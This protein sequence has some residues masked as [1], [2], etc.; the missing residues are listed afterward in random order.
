MPKRKPEWQTPPR[1]PAG[2]NANLDT[3]IRA[4]KQGDLVVLSCR[5]GATGKPV[6]VVC[7]I[8]RGVEN[9][10]AMFYPVP[11]AAL[12]D[13]NPYALLQDPTADVQAA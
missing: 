5:W 13:G 1:L 9:G 12:F 8:N 6:S 7:A 2:T 3:I 4:A 10:Q 11:L